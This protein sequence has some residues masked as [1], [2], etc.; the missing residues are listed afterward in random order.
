[1]YHENMT[2]L[3]KDTPVPN[4]DTSAPKKEAPQ[5][6]RV[7][8]PEGKATP[9]QVKSAIDT[10]KTSKAQFDKSRRDRERKQQ[11]LAEKKS[12]S[13]SAEADV[14]AEPPFDVPATYEVKS[15]IPWA[16][17]ITYNLLPW[18]QAPDNAVKVNKPKKPSDST[19]S[20]E[21]LELDKKKQEEEKAVMESLRLKHT[22]EIDKTL[23]EFDFSQ[24]TDEEKK[25]IHA[26][27]L[28][29]WVD[30]ARI[31]EE[32]KKAALSSLWLTGKVDVNNLTP[33]QLQMVQQHK[34]K[35]YLKVLADF[36]D[37]PPEELEKKH[38]GIQDFMKNVSQIYPV[39]ENSA[40]VDQNWVFDQQK[41]F[42]QVKKDPTILS[43]TI[44]SIKEDGFLLSGISADSQ[45]GK[46]LSQ[47]IS[48]N[49]DEY[50]D[51]SKPNK[52]LVDLEHFKKLKDIL[53]WSYTD[54]LFQKNS[55]SGT[56][57]NSKIQ[58]MYLCSSSKMRYLKCLFQN[59]EMLLLQKNTNSLLN[60]PY[61][62]IQE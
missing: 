17:N 23:K 6:R 20:P 35:E 48:D 24:L 50:L 19:K 34:A 28:S 21:E 2:E 60:Q 30:T 27:S 38:P 10:Y 55:S 43:E 11:E 53:G 41:F 57:M 40:F 12:D 16:P 26:N 5:E 29:R 61:H 37:V 47:I 52:D 33:E 45:L 9:E 42:E 49:V 39:W 59:L 18:Q 36:K 54:L 32:D 31:T 15:H 51:I 58:E 7:V 3:K 44:K 22:E 46:A 4:P 14:D 13:G 56:I 25:M 8:L 62:Q 1:M